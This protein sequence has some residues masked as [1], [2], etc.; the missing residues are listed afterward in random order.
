MQV[1][2]M[3]DNRGQVIIKTISP[4]KINGREFDTGD[5]LAVLDDV[6]IELAY[7]QNDSL[8][9]KANEILLQNAEAAPTI[10]VLD[11]IKNNTAIERLLYTATDNQTIAATYVLNVD[12]DMLQDNVYYLIDPYGKA[13]S[14]SEVKSYNEN[15][16]LNVEFNEQDLSLKFNDE[17]FGT[18]A[19]VISGNYVAKEYTLHKKHHPYVSVEIKL[20]GNVGT[21]KGYLV[22]HIPAAS[23]NTNPNFD[24]SRT[25]VNY[26][27][28]LVYSVINTGST[29]RPTIG[30]IEI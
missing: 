7:S 29:Q 10:L 19:I 25:E 30:F 11:D 5:I 27:T 28:R 3:F 13:L 14:Y 17:N 1:N 20:K 6:L 9:T 8:A 4:R 23:L 2:K 16:P 15:G 22:I 21:K 12:E 26:A 18:A 24:F